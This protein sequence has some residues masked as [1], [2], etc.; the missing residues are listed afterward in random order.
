MLNQGSSL[1]IQGVHHIDIHFQAGDIIEVYNKEG[2]YLLGKGKVRLSSLDL[3]SH[4]LSSPILIHRDDWIAFDH[5]S[6][7]QE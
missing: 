1:L 5:H 7:L 4:Q 2:D 6:W 3:N